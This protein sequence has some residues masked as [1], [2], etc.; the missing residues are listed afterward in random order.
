MVEHK[1]KATRYAHAKDRLLDQWVA[2][3]RSESITDNGT[4]SDPQRTN[5]NFNAEAESEEEVD[6]VE[7]DDSVLVPWGQAAPD[8][9]VK[10]LSADD[11]EEEGSYSEDEGITA[12]ST[13]NDIGSQTASPDVND[14]DLPPFRPHFE[15]LADQSAWT[16]L[17]LD[18]AISV[19]ACI[20]HYLWPYQREGVGFL[21]EKYSQG[22]GGVL[23]DDMG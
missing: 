8:A 12:R 20:N 6:Y 9:R 14:Q 15:P 1:S 7:D 21:Y 2:S 11:L 4:E 23:G 18:E 17:K 10:D 19:P 13:V 22:I 3:N 16:P 5:C